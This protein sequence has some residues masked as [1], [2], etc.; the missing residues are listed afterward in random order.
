LRWG[1]VPHWAKD[2]NIGYK[3]INA[4]S[5][6]LTEKPSFRKPFA[7]RR[8]IIPA[9]GFYEWRKIGDKKIP[10]Y[11]RV[12]EQDVAGF[13]GLYE[14]WKAPD[15]SILPTFTIITTTANTLIEPLHER[16]PVILHK[17]DYSRWLDG[18]NNDT[19]ELQAMLQPYPTERMSV[20]RVSDAVNKSGTND[21][22]FIEPV[23][24]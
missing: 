22:S 10:F 20:Y 11:I 6:T 16:M 15:N 3:M 4:R 18:E 13:A 17:E 23:N 21:P 14:K 9:N 1:L 19:E 2:T 24:V 7:S 8:C 12:N 5:E